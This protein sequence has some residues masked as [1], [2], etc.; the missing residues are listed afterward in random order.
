MTASTAALSPVAIWMHAIRPKTLFASIAPIL[1]G[2]GVARHEDGFHLPAALVSLIV[3]LLLQILSNL[4]NDYFDHKRGADHNRIG[5]LRVTQAGLVTDAQMQAAIGITT[6]LALIGGIYLVARGG[7][8]ILV[9]GLLAILC[10][11]IYTGG[12]VPLG[13]HALGD[14]FVFIFFGLVGVAGSAYVQTRDLTW[15]ALVAA[16]PI[17][18]LATAIIVANNLRDIE[19]DRA[20]GKQTLATLLGRSG[21][22]REY[23]VLIAVAFVI[24]FLLALFGDAPMAWLPI[25]VVLPLAL[26]LV[27]AV[28]SATGPALIPVLVGTSR[29]TAIFGAIFAAGIIL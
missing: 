5:P 15:F 9:I 16:I 23:Q 17:G 22:I 7:W 1:V 18:C 6:A 19:T 10:A 21:A 13:Y 24:P 8:P 29:L 2:S 3:A 28:R 27:A 26:P 11:V 25:P 14:L 12:P 4:A 20:A